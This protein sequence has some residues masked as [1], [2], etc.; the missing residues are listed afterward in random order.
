MKDRAK[1]ILFDKLMEEGWAELLFP[2]QKISHDNATIQIILD[3]MITF[4][5]NETQS[6][7]SKKAKKA[8]PK[9]EIIKVTT[10]T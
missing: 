2:T 3:A 10:T 7:E 9:A 8:F 6:K 4:H 5:K 1:R